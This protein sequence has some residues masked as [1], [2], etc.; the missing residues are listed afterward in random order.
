MIQCFGMKGCNISCT[1]GVGP[2]LSLNHREENL[3]NEE[4]K[5]V[6]YSSRVLSSILNRF[7]ATTASSLLNS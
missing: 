7:P 3:L 6:T 4:G 1:P 5:N 2:E